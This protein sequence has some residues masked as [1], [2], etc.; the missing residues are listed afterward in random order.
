M[1]IYFS[2]LLACDK[3]HYSDPYVKIYLMPGKKEKRKTKIIN[4]N[5]NPVF[6]ET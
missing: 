6:D 1:Y 3:D 5:L 2:C 4:N